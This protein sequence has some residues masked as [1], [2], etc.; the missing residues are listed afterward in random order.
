MIRAREFSPEIIGKEVR[1][2]YRQVLAQRPRRGRRA[3]G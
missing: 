1:E 2:I 3:S